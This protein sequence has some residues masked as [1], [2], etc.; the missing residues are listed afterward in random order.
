[1]SD[2]IPT[3]N[4]NEGNAIVP[5]AQLWHSIEAPRPVGFHD[6]KPPMDLR[7]AEQ[8][9][10][11]IM[12]RLSRPSGCTRGELESLCSGRL[13]LGR[14]ARIY[15][16]QVAMGVRPDGVRYQAVRPGEEPTCFDRDTIWTVL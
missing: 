13:N 4:L 16:M 6:P 5:L 7:Q 12:C 10:R 14:L 9:L 15:G 1:M 2:I 3:P 11:D 8:R